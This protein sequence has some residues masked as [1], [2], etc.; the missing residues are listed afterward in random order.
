M[1]RFVWVLVQR[2]R[3]KHF[4]GAKFDDGAEISLGNWAKIA[5]W[6]GNFPAETTMKTKTQTLTGKEEGH[7]LVII[8]S[9]A[10]FYNYVIIGN[11]LLTLCRS[12][13]IIVLR[14]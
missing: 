10:V 6:S 14:C 11:F 5:F 13:I 2:I 9:F 7:E 4:H 1:C 3:W 8:N 12:L